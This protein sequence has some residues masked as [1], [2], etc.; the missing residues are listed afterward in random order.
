MPIGPVFN[1]RVHNRQQNFIVFPDRSAEEAAVAEARHGEIT[2]K[3]DSQY[4]EQIRA[5]ES[6]E[7]AECARLR[8]EA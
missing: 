6:H 4:Q 7:E 8:S 2:A 1:M 5:I 3:K